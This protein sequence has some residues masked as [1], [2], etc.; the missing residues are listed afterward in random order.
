MFNRHLLR[1]LNSFLT[2]VGHPLNLVWLAVFVSLLSQWKE[3]SKL[4]STDAKD[5]IVIGHEHQFIF[6]G[7]DIKKKEK[8]DLDL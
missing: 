6:W 3:W 7:D 5:I 4:L 2:F 1:I 8:N